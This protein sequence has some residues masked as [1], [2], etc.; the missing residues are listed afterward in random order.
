M[1]YLVTLSS[2]IGEYSCGDTVMYYYTYMY[3]TIMGKII[4]CTNYIGLG[5]ISRNSLS[6]ISALGVDGGT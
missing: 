2:C 1:V 5:G 6:R 3:C 4:L